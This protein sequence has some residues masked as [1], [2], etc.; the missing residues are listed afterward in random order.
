MAKKELSRQKKFDTRIDFTPMVD[1]NML[2]ITF[3]M[4]CTTMIKSQTL[5]VALPT[6]EKVEQQ[7]QEQAKQSEAL[8]IIVDGGLKKA[9]VEGKEIMMSDL[10]KSKF[11]YYDGQANLEA[12]N[13]IESNMKGTG[14]GTLR[15]I[16]RERNKAAIDLIDKEKERWR[17]GEISEDE[18]NEKRAKIQD[19]SNLKR[20]VVMIKPTKQAS[21]ADVVAVLD[22]MQIN[23][24]SR[25]RIETLSA[26]DSTLL[27]G[28][29]VDL[30]TRK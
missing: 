5:S 22:E 4:L 1:M 11:Y 29:G 14:D 2:L 27:K 24:I 30:S 13:M 6:N 28:L 8:T 19:D 17:K 20:P 3:F 9:T 18:Y 21:Y 26:A 12:P 10:D 16:F 15:Y 23:N 7:D 25:W